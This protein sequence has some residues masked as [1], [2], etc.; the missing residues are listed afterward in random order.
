[1]KIGNKIISAITSLVFCCSAIVSFKLNANAYFLYGYKLTA[2][3]SECTCFYPD[4][5]AS[6]YGVRIMR[7]ATSWQ[8]ADNLSFDLHWLRTDEVY[9]RTACVLTYN[10]D[11]SVLA[12]TEFYYLDVNTLVSC[13]PTN[14][15]W[16]NCI[17]RINTAYNAEL[18]YTTM[19][20]EFGH[21]M[22]LGH[23]DYDPTSIMC[24]T[25]YGRTATSPSSD[26]ID[27]LN[28]LYS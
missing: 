8:F 13:K 25:A 18:D 12:Y 22:G 6:T 2:D 11:D 3:M 28:E 15:N 7:G 14:R 19:I 17:I 27:G 9:E 5:V 21:V 24:Q 10:A 23:V 1:M 26:D 4:G 16:D 20:H